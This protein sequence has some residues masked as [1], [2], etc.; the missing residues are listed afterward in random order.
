[1]TIFVTSHFPEFSNMKLNFIPRYILKGLL[2][3][4]VKPTTIVKCSY[5]CEKN[6]LITIFF[7]ME[8]KTPKNHLT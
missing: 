4:Y 7:K 3:Q 8:S 1:M 6:R 5:K 2:F